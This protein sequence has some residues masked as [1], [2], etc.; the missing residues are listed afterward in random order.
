MFKS[1]DLFDLLNLTKQNSL[2]KDK[3]LY[4]GVT[5]L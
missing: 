5:G 1:Q 2:Y 3:L 4:L